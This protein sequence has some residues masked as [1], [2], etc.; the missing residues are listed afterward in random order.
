MPGGGP[1]PHERDGASVF[2]RPAKGHG[3]ESDG[4][5]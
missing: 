2:S 3:V 1:V 4:V 5:L